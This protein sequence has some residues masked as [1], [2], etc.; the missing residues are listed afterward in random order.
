MPLSKRIFNAL[1]AIALLLIAALVLFKMDFFDSYIDKFNDPDETKEYGYKTARVTIGKNEQLNHNVYIEDSIRPVKNVF[2]N[3]F[4]GSP[5]LAA[6]IEGDGI[7]FTSKT[8]FSEVGDYIYDVYLYTENASIQRMRMVVHVEN[9]L[10]LVKKESLVNNGEIF[11][12]DTPKRIIVI[13]I[14]DMLNVFNRRYQYTQPFET[15]NL[16][17]IARHGTVFTAANATTPVCFASRASMWSG[18]SSLRHRVGLDKN[19]WRKSI[20]PDETTPGVLK[21]S[22]YQVGLYGKVFHEASKVKTSFDVESYDEM[23]THWKQPVGFKSAIRAEHEDRLR[24]NPFSIHYGP[25]DELVDVNIADQAVNFLVNE[26]DPDKPF[27]LAVGFYKPHSSWGVP[28]RFFDR[29]NIEEISIPLLEV[30]DYSDI[31]SWAQKNIGQMLDAH[32]TLGSE[33]QWA[34]AIQAYMAALLYVD[35]QLGKVIAALESEGL[36]NNSVVI[37]A[38]DHGYH[39]GEKDRWQKYTLWEEAVNTPLVISM[40]QREKKSLHLKDRLRKVNT[41]PVSLADI[42]STVLDIAGVSKGDEFDGRSLVEMTVNPKTPLA[43][44]RQAILTV[45]KGSYSLR[46]QKMR[47]TIYEDGSEELY[48]LERDPWSSVNLI[49]NNEW[50]GERD[51]LRKKITTLIEL[52]S[53]PS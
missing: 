44:E 1:G 29:I 52:E 3:E 23:A 47:Y 18:K 30:E 20:R 49:N 28:K 19:V 38:S 15:P 43:T 27:F 35:E 9:E 4:Y 10:E 8:K 36:D 2:I 46:T 25:D 17:R 6:E 45:I 41:R 50:A 33:L 14:D 16:D 39:L 37:V 22:A 40:P 42:H 21:D 32:S 24:L 7:T 48:Y 26:V 11:S 53:G 5:I 51:L 12:S 31:P 13:T 34:R